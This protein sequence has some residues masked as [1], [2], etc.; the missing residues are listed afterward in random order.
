VDAA[1]ESLEITKETRVAARWDA[2]IEDRETN[3]PVWTRRDL[4]HRRA[5]TD[6]ARFGQH[7]AGGRRSHAVR[8]AVH[9]RSPRRQ[10]SVRGRRSRLGGAAS[11]TAGVAVFPIRGGVRPG[12]RWFA[13]PGLIPQDGGPTWRRVR[14]PITAALMPRCHDLPG[15]WMLAIEAGYGIR[16]SPAPMSPGGRRRT[17]TPPG[18]PTRT[19]FDPTDSRPDPTGPCLWHETF[20]VN[21]PPAAEPG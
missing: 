9:L 3:P 17:T 6:E 2:L 4:A 12:A 20:G 18:P 10:Q 15:D 13:G 21:G 14:A 16:N 5:E 1:G 19:A 7:P 11:H 8:V